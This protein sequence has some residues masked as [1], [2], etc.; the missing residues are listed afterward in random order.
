MLFTLL[1]K[2]VS[3]KVVTMPSELLFQNRSRNEVCPRNKRS[4]NKTPFAAKLN[5]NA[6]EVQ[7]ERINLS[8]L[9]SRLRNVQP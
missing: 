3:K 8:V 9:K 6:T 2:K 7:L 1:P 4:I 5:V